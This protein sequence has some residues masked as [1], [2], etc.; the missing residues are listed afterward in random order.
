MVEIWDFPE[1][2]DTF[3]VVPTMNIYISISILESP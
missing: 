2:K 1:I 3:L